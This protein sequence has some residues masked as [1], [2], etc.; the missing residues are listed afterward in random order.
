MAD[1]CGLD[2]HFEPSLRPPKRLFKM[3]PI[4]DERDCVCVIESVRGSP[5]VEDHPKVTVTLRSCDSEMRPAELNTRAT[6]SGEYRLNTR[7]EHADLALPHRNASGLTLTTVNTFSLGVVQEHVRIETAAGDT[8]RLQNDTFPNSTDNNLSSVCVSNK[9]APAG[10]E[11]DILSTALPRDGCDNLHK[12]MT[13]SPTYSDG[14]GQ[15]LVSPDCNHPS[16]HKAA[17]H[18]PQTELQ[19]DLPH[20]CYESN[21]EDACFATEI[22]MICESQDFFS[23]PT[24]H[25]APENDCFSDNAYHNN[26]LESVRQSSSSDYFNCDLKSENSSVYQSAQEDFHHDEYENIELSSIFSSSDIYQR[27]FDHS[28][29]TNSVSPSEENSNSSSNLITDLDSRSCEKFMADSGVFGLSLSDTGS[30]FFHSEGMQYPQSSAQ[31]E[32]VSDKTEHDKDSVSLFK[33]QEPFSISVAKSTHT[34]A[35]LFSTSA[36]SSTHTGAALFSTRVTNSIHTNAGS[37]LDPSTPLLNNVQTGC[38]EHHCGVQ[39]KSTAKSTFN[40]AGLSFCR[41]AFD[42]SPGVPSFYDPC[43]SDYYRYVYHSPYSHSTSTEWKSWIK[44]SCTVYDSPESQITSKQPADNCPVSST[45][46]RSGVT[47]PEIVQFIEIDDE[48][49]TDDADEIDYLPVCFNINSDI[50]EGHMDPQSVGTT[51]Y[52]SENSTADYSPSVLTPPPSASSTP[53]PSTTLESTSDEVD[54]SDSQ[55]RPHYNTS[56]AYRSPTGQAFACKLKHEQLQTSLLSFGLS[57]GAKRPYPSMADVMRSSRSKSATRKKS[58]QEGS[59]QQPRRSGRPRKTQI[60]SDT[61][62]TTAVSSKQRK[63]TASASKSKC[64]PSMPD[65]NCLMKSSE[66]QVSIGSSS[67]MSGTC[68]HNEPLNQ[69][70]IGIMTQWFEDHIDNPYPSKSDKEKMAVQGGITENQVKSWFANKRN[71]TNNTKPKVQKR[72]MEEK[73]KEIFRDLK[74]NHQN[75]MADNSH[76]IQQLS[77]IIQ[78]CHSAKLT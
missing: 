59:D 47:K 53:V 50:C 13:S 48:E 76:V 75:P 39:Q 78:H 55:P 61:I 11:C 41:N 33:P 73:L 34:S 5:Y 43:L 18:L 32:T 12:T 44:G 65:V 38:H 37:F 69:H 29:T 2:K 24:E 74:R 51:E 4:T 72:A 49:E 27:S 57:Q 71:R 30:E 62:S 70:A 21:E 7:L 26:A 56:Q 60:Q 45:G 15:N 68:R 52:H 40:S 28:Y 42:K 9:C 31:L 66:D 25:N 1:F 36:A 19:N 54:M 23:E 16:Q 3:E 58:S 6:F 22:T 20:V 64:E 10:N 35:A 67:R 8:G 14:S 63:R 46:I 17:S 77:G